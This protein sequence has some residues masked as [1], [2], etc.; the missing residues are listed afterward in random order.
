MTFR[1][2]GIFVVLAAIL[3][4]FFAIQS[5][6]ATRNIT[7]AV[8]DA[9]GQTVG[10]YAGSYALLVGVSDYTAGWPKLE[11]VPGEMA[12]LKKALEG[13]GFTVTLVMNPDGRHIQDAFRDFISEYGYDADNRLLFYFSGHGYSLDN[14]NKG[15]LVPADAPDP[16]K[17]RKNFLRKALDM[18]ELLA[19]SRKMTAKHALFLFDSC[20]SGSIFKTRALPKEPPYITA[21]T[22]LP[23]RQFITAGSAG[24]EVPA[25]SVFTP[26]FIDALTYGWGD[27]NKDGYISGME[28]GLY[29]QGEVPQ[30]A[31]QS[32]QFG[33]IQDYDPSRGDFVF[34]A[35]GAAVVVT[36]GGGTASGGAP[37][38]GPAKLRVTTEPAGAEV[39][40]D[41]RSVGRAPLFLGELAPGE[42]FVRATKDGFADGDKVVTVQAGKVTQVTLVLEKASTSGRLFVKPEPA[43]ATVKVL[44]I[45]PKYQ[46]GMELAAGRY[47]VEV[48]KSGFEPQRQWVDL[49]AG[50]DL[51]VRVALK[52]SALASALLMPEERVMKQKGVTGGPSL[53]DT[54]NQL[55]VETTPAPGTTWTEPTMGMEFVWVPGG[56][57]QMGS[58][59]GEADEKPVH[60]V[61]VDGYWMGKYEVTNAQYRKFKSGHDS[62]KYEGVS[63]NGGNQPV[64]YVSCEDAQAFVTWL[65]QRG[66]GSGTFRLPTEAEWEYAARGGTTTSRFWGDDPDQACGY[67][68][69]SD[70]TA[71]R[72]WPGWTI[73]GCDDGFAATAPV[74]SFRPN[75]FGLYDMLGNVWEWT[76]DIYGDKAYGSL[77]RDNPI[78]T[79][80]G[81]YRVT[82]G[83]S[84]ADAPA[85]V[86]CAFRGNRE[87][88][89]RGSGLG[90]RLVRTAVP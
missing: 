5:S 52:E 78:Y 2:I 38:A 64:V 21:A 24:E 19:W 84:W 49:A 87:S 30:H 4:G 42:V 61:C 48:T 35:G 39:F 53:L 51:E 71:K 11:S 36:D 66:A 73:T 65:N 68:N 74:G 79:G 50:Q 83:G 62:G 60:E 63:L 22:A 7:V 56:C 9:G 69:I 16:N 75:A 45:G 41:G 59:D 77:G 90:F 86:R 27:L 6:A 12:G 47:H 3:C 81:S 70:R 55:Q 89:G 31:R 25:R 85:H 13:Q 15:Y 88:G 28:L 1:N 58:Y 17:D 29:L 32:P 44:N 14:G 80:G 40:V 67:A 8:K 43:D 26:A 82:R 76:E 37:A 46:E 33:K 18:T 10:G 20:F 72:Q 57:F 34:V 54:L 23:V